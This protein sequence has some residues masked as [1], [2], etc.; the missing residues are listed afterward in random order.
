MV[1]SGH[2]KVVWSENQ[3]VIYSGSLNGVVCQWDCRTGRI[4]REW[5]G[6]KDAILDL[7]VNE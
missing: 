3:P 6:H 1:Q 5:T 7:S 2:V 4:E